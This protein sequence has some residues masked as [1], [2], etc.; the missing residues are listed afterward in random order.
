MRC[1]IC[2]HG[3]TA[4]ATTTVTLERGGMTLV[5]KNVPAQV[6]ENCGE[7]YLDEATTARLLA[8]AEEAARAGVQV[9]VREYVAA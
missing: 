9:D 6:C 8:T 2:K 4:P 5:F 7:A 1:V 3:D